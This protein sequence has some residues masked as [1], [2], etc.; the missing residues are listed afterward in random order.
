MEILKDN[1]KEDLLDLA[2]VTAI[3][4][5]SEC[6]DYDFDTARTMMWEVI[7]HDRSH[8]NDVGKDK[9][10]DNDDPILILLV[11]DESSEKTVDRY[12]CVENMEDAADKI[13]DHMKPNDLKMLDGSIVYMDYEACGSEEDIEWM[14]HEEAD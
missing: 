11:F 6:G 3:E 13:G 4:L 1:D 10:H 14:M 12:T 8:F 9:D 2:K 5:P 7:D